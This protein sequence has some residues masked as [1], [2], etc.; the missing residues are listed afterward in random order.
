MTL[1]RVLSL[2]II[3]LVGVM[4]VSAARRMDLYT[5]EFG[6]T[7]LRLWTSVFMAWLGVLFVVLVAG[8][9]RLRANAFSFGLALVAIGFFATMNLINPD[10]RIAAHNIDRALAGE[11]DFDLC[12]L[13]QLSMD[14]TPVIVDRSE[15]RRAARL[16]AL[17]AY[18]QVR[19]DLHSTQTAGD[20]GAY[21][22]GWNGAIAAVA[23]V[24]AT[25]DDTLLLNCNW[26]RGY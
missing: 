25:A 6:L 26:S 16:G 8:L 5:D 9:L 13:S 15:T 10:G 2:V 18:L 11:I 14:A 21:H 7:R 3:A 12:Y 22:L 1:F 23:D 24:D 20:L 19:A 17:V 4:L